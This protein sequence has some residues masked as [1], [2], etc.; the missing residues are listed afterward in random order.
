MV[1]ADPLSILGISLRIMFISRLVGNILFSLAAIIRLSPLAR[2]PCVRP[3]S[4]YRLLVVHLE[5]LAM[6]LPLWAWDIMFVVPKPG[7]RTATIP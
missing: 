6:T 1:T 7:R 5:S 3:A 2:A 4:I